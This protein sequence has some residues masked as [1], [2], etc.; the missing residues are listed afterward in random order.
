MRI[1]SRLLTAL[2]I[3]H[4]VAC[5]FATTTPGFPERKPKIAILQCSYDKDAD[6]SND[7]KKRITKAILEQ[8]SASSV[9]LRRKDQGA[10]S[11]QGICFE[12]R[13]FRTSEAAYGLVESMGLD[14]GFVVD[15][16]KI[17][18]TLHIVLT[19]FDYN[20]T[21]HE[22]PYS[23]QTNRPLNDVKIDAKPF[24]EI[25]KNPNIGGGR[26]KTA[27]VLLSA[28]GGIAIGILAAIILGNGGE[29][30]DSG[31]PNP[32]AIHR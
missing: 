28:A 5:L 25:A 24:L 26:G 18:G 7:E 6:L 1:K 23:F 17:A 10:S 8:V 14:A 11:M 9:E 19:R 27:I 32:P 3:S 29:K 2:M 12:L 13:V 16:E 22:Y 20:E 30:S 4:T 15:V 21:V 31:R